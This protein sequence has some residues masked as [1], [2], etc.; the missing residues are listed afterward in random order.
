M[1]N[2]CRFFFFFF[3]IFLTDLVFFWH[4]YVSIYILFY[5]VFL[6]LYPGDGR[7]YDLIFEQSLNRLDELHW[8]PEFSKKEQT[9]LSLYL[10]KKE[11]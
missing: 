3:D 7:E 11:R 9:S 2:L 6:F 10:T 5:F 1:V 4:I 8:G